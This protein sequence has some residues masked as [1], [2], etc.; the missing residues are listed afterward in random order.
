M[1]PTKKNGTR[2]SLF[3]VCTLLAAAAVQAETFSV[4]SPDGKAQVE[5]IAEDGQ[6]SYSLSWNDHQILTSSR[7]S[8]FRTG[9]LEPTRSEEIASNTNW[10]TVWGQHRK[11][12]DHFNGIVVHLNLNQQPEKLA[13][14]CRV[15]D[16]GVGIRFMSKNGS[17]GMPAK[18]EFTTEHR[19]SDDSQLYWPAG[20]RDPTGPVSMTDFATLKM[21]PLIPIVANC[22]NGLFTALLESDLY[23]AKTFSSLRFERTRKLPRLLIAKSVGST[24]A[25]AWQTPWRL[26][27]FGDSPGSLVESTTALNLAAPCELSDTSWIKPGK[28]LWDWRVHGYETDGFTYGVDTA[29][30]LRFIDFAAENDIEYFLID[31]EWYHAAKGGRLHASE[32]LDMPKIMEHARKRDVGIILY[33]DRK[34]GTLENEILFPLLSDLGAPGTKYGFMGNNATFTRRAIEDAA[35]HK[36]VINFHDG[37]CPM[38]GVERTLPNALTREYCHAQQ[39]SR[40]AFG[41]TGFLKMAMINSLTGPLD[42]TNGAFGLD[43]I[44][45]GERQR[46]PKAKQSFNS[47]VVSEVARVLVIFSGWVSLPDAPE[48]YEKKSDLFDFIRRMPTTWDETRILNSKMETYI[49]TARRSGD[50]WFVGSVINEDGGKLA[51]PLGFLNKDQAYE[52][53]FYTDTEDSHFKNNREAYAIRTE[54]KTSTDTIIATLAPGG[55]HCMWIRPAKSKAP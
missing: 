2:F 51:I 7:I 48:E 13:M 20:E 12:R 41:P 8:L 19:W 49:T 23:S 45:A 29:S 55:G 35:E 28:V 54:R 1:N 14:E 21:K 36:M 34:K 43:G 33:Y 46:G 22:G 38:V 15:Y 30:Y 6:L 26:V 4:S 39:D 53:T 50:E 52:I 9:S 40:R 44:N 5:I 32:D 27:L 11:I 17:T 42:Q 3:L 47:T 24:S 25:E 10:E 18:V 16:D 37:P 31:D